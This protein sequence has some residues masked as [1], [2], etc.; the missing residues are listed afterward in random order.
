MAQPKHSLLIPVMRSIIQRFLDRRGE[1]VFRIFLLFFA[2]FMT[3]RM[4]WADPSDG[5]ADPED[6]SDDLDLETETEEEKKEREAAEKNRL[7]DDDSLD[8]LDDEDE[9]EKIEVEDSEA[10]EGDLLETEIGKD[11]IGGDGEDNA[12]IYRDAQAKFGRMIPD[13]EMNDMKCHNDNDSGHHDCMMIS[14][15]TLPHQICSLPFAR[16][17]M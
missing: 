10:G 15:N 17:A 9:L 5:W 4:A 3:P 13:E 14:E 2:L 8:L 7:D 12:T 11:V 6:D 1:H 16:R